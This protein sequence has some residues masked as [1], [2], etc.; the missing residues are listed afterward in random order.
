ML[1]LGAQSAAQ[2]AD[3]DILINQ[4][5]AMQGGITPNDAP[6]FPITLAKGGHY[7]LVGPLK[8]PRDVQGMY[9]PV[10]ADGITI[11]FNGFEMTGGGTSVGID[12]PRDSVG[13]YSYVS[14]LDVRNGTIQNFNLGIGFAEQAR[15]ENMRL[16]NNGRNIDVRSGARIVGNITDGGSVNCYL[17][18]LMQGNI[19][20]RGSV[21]I[22]SG[23][24]IGNTVTTPA[25]DIALHGGNFAPM[26]YGNNTIFNENGK[27]VKID[28][29]T[30]GV[31]PLDPN[32]CGQHHPCLAV[33]SSP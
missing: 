7:K 33:P 29:G 26:G 11:D 21:L 6:G 12:S 28:G 19:V 10:M 9:I 22:E 18:C 23:T 24:F 17:S 5:R 20:R 13:H 31:G 15:I 25:G 32:Y 3:S 14:R 4:Q 27:D 2:A 1:A 30:A 16:L 8:V